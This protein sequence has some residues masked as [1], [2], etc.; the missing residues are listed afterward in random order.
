M[1]DWSEFLFLARAILGGMLV[2]WGDFYKF[3]YHEE[4]QAI[5]EYILILAVGALGAATFVRG[6]FGILD[7]GIYSFGGQ[8]EK[9]LR[10]GRMPLDFW[11]EPE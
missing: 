9:D 2:K 7:R 11:K 3:L 4:G 8:L 10:T 1:G 6:L 5:T